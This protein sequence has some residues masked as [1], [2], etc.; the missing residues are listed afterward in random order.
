MILG[1]ERPSIVLEQLDLIFIFFF[2][3]PTFEK[4]SLRHYATCRNG[5]SVQVSYSIGLFGNYPASR[6]LFPL[7]S[8]LPYCEK[9]C[10]H[11]NSETVRDS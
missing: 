11:F 9:P 4:K 8:F 7:R 10:Y 2:L 3:P 1:V 5:V 6:N